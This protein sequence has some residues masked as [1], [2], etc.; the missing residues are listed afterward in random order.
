MNERLQ[1]AGAGGRPSLRDAHRA[2]TRRLILDATADLLSREHPAV[3]SMSAVAKRAGVSEATLFRYFPSKE[4]LL[5]AL[6]LRGDEQS[7]ASVGGG[8]PSL[9]ELPDYL[10]RLW[11]ELARDLPLFRAQ[12][13]S[14]VGRD[15]RRRRLERR[16]AEIA[17]TLR[18]GGIDLD[19]TDGSRLA[20]VVQLLG[21]SAALL[22][23][24][25]A[26]GLPVETAADAIAWAVGELI[27]AV[28][29]R[30]QTAPLPPQAEKQM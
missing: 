22:E 15:V 27:D 1:D 14:P 7:R 30:Q 19:G 5:D 16:T 25:D 2:T 21:S 6:S 3:L 17:A 11:P 20:A 26:M 4:A 23:L 13:L 29:A 8:R 18:E 10:R 28:R 9:A 24:H 12:L